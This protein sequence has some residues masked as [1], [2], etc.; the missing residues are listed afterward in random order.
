MVISV[1][2]RA[3]NFVDIKFQSEIIGISKIHVIWSGKYFAIMKIKAFKSIV[4]LWHILI[5][6]NFLY[7]DFLNFP[8]VFIIG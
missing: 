7:F 3:E 2:D 1:C 5:L 8:I 6:M 4:H